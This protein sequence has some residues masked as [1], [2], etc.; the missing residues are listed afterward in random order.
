VGSW[1]GWELDEEVDEEAE[2]DDF[3]IGESDDDEETKELMK[4]K[5]EQI[6]EIQKR[7]EAGRAKAKSNLT[8]DIA[9]ES[10]ETDMKALEEKVRAI[11]IEG[12]T[13]LGGQLVDIA[14][15]IKKLRILCQLVDVLTN[16]DTIREAVEAIPEVQSTDIF[17]FQ[18]A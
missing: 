15:G 12:A 8:L 18:M 16:P 5:A 17:A 14:F 10:S 9:P 1:G 11:K 4:K 13:W 7:Q 6:K 2:D 3:D